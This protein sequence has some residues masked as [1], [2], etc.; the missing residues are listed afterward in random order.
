MKPL[1]FRSLLTLTLVLAAAGCGQPSGTDGGVDAGADGGRD[2]GMDAGVDGGTDGGQEVRVP[3][4]P[5]G[6]VASAGPAQATL[7]WTAPADTGGSPLTGFRVTPHLAGVAGTPIQI[8]GGGTTSTVVTGLTNGPAYTF[9]VAAQNAVGTGPDSTASNEVVPAAVPGA[10][11]GVT[12]TAGNAQA[13]VFWSAPVDTGGSA[14]TGFVV[15]PFAGAV[16]QTAVELND[17]GATSA[18]IVGLTNG[19][20]YTFRVAAKNAVGTGADSAPSNAVTPSAPATAPAAPT[21]VTATAG[22]GQ[23]VL[24]W[25]APSTGGSPLTHY[26]ITP[27]AAGVE[28]AP[29]TV[30]S[31]SATTATLAPLTN[32]TEYSFTVAAANAVGVGPA[33]G[34]TAAV[35]PSTV[36]G[37]PTALRGM[38]GDGTLTVHWLP[39]ASDGGRPISGY[40]VTASPGGASASTTGATMVTLTG[41][42]NGQAFTL[43]VV[44]SNANGPGLPAT[45]RMVVAPPCGV[46]GLPSPPRENSGAVAY[47]L[48]VGDLNEDGI[49]DLVGADFDG[50]QLHVLIARGDG[51]FEPAASYATGARP[52]AI[53]IGDLNGDGHLDLVSAHYTFPGTI[54]VFTGAGDGTLSAAGDFAVGGRPES[55]ALGDLNADGELDAVVAMVGDGDQPVAVLAGNGDATFQSA[56]PYGSGAGSAVAISDLNRDSRPDLVVA[57]FAA[58]RILVLMNSGTG[59]FPAQ[60]Q[61][62]S[63]TNPLE[64]VSADFNGDLSPDVASLNFGA[65]TISVLLGTGTGTLGTKVDYGSGSGPNSLAVGDLNG[66][67]RVDLVASDSNISG[68]LRVLFGNANGTF[69]PA[70][71][72]GTGGAYSVAVADVNQDGALDLAAGNLTSPTLST[73]LGNGDGS[74][75]SHAV[76]GPPLVNAPARVV[77]G[78]LNRD[79]RADVAVLGGNGTVTLLNGDG[80]GALTPA[81]NVALQLVSLTLADFDLDG[82]LDLAGATAERAVGVAR[83]TSSGSF[84]PFEGRGGGGTSAILAEDFNRDGRPDLATAHSSSGSAFVFLGNGDGTLRAPVEATAG[85]FA[86]ALASADFDADGRPD[87]AVANQQGN[88]VSVLRGR[89][90]GTFDGKVGLAAG[91]APN[92]LVTHD[93]NGD[94]HADLA[95]TSETDGAVS[96]LLGTGN[97]GFSSATSFPAGAGLRALTA[98]DLNGDGWMDLAAVRYTQQALTVLVGNGDG[99]FGPPQEW[100]APPRP[101]ALLATDLNADGRADLVTTADSAPGVGVFLGD[102]LP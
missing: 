32:G 100:N 9:T 73:L 64:L 22:N 21:G 24:A 1:A 98:V 46:C 29:I 43:S 34:P 65:G 39:P 89:G 30:S 27:T 68:Q 87:L 91:A 15:T 58:S 62:T 47:E 70:V 23:V 11:S 51:T 26:L 41:L 54:R 3:G 90:D 69:Q 18:I 102:C 74:F 76:Y 6:V 38:A 92:A 56:V 59:T 48:Q 78:D 96:I 2:A 63:G 20:A 7:A 94:G 4:A 99:T 31:G 84:L 40:S 19:S 81:G 14:L 49:P 101:S 77:P 66:D 8:A 75:R 10:P 88:T 79:G 33:S 80:S 12:A 5:E 61:F 67:G 55:V 95:A 50:N 71:Q 52:K 57:A 97:G 36:P 44:A 28:G 86:T 16:A 60:T 25:T 85:S 45:T 37:V 82:R 35:T 42:T 53:A 17:P 83:R 93:F 13:T 72:V